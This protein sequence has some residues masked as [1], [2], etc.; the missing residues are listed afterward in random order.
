M[1]FQLTLWFVASFHID[2]DIIY[3]IDE[4]NPIRRFRVTD[5]YNYIVYRKY[6]NLVQFSADILCAPILLSITVPG[7]SPSKYN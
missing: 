1:I 5:S 2:E 7:L 6:C 3:H 4:N